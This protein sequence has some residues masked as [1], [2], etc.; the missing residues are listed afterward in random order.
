MTNDVQTKIDKLYNQV[1]SSVEQG[2]FPHGVL[3]ECQ[4]E[5]SEQTLRYSEKRYSCFG[6]TRRKGSQSVI[7]RADPVDTEGTGKLLLSSGRLEQGK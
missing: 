4:N 1:S 5:H 6:K 3:V 2:A 7:P